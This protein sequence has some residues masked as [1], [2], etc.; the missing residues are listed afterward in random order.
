MGGGQGSSRAMFNVGC[1]VGLGWPL[2]FAVPSTAWKCPGLAT[3]SAVRC[4]ALLVYAMQTCQEM[5]AG[6]VSGLQVIALY[7]RL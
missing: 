2:F 4:Q 7:G 3:R 1:K 6:V 5:V